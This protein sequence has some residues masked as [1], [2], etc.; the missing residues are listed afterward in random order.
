MSAKD[1]VELLNVPARSAL[2]ILNHNLHSVFLFH[3]YEWFRA[4]YSRARV[5]LIDG[6]PVLRLTS[7]RPSAEVRIGSTDWLAALQQEWR[8]S[9]GSQVRRVFLLGGDQQSNAAARR[10]LADGAPD[11]VVHGGHGFFDLDLDSAQVV[12][13]LTG[14]RPD[15]VLVGMGM[16]RQEEFLERNLAQLPPAY[17]ATV[18]GAIDYL[19]EKSPLAPRAFGRLGIEWLWRFLHAP[20]RLFARYFIEPFHLLGLLIAS[21]RRVAAEKLRKQN[22]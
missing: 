16:P 20:S 3:K 14:F 2:L 22:K 15:L 1:V 13:E 6:W 19:A 18:G 11:I 9:E 21:R 4:F 5:V 7:G 10:R 8:R 17:Y 12:A